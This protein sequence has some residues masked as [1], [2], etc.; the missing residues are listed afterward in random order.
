MIVHVIGVV[1]LLCILMIVSLSV[2]AAVF[3]VSLGMS[4]RL[5]LVLLQSAFCRY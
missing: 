5:L 4:T 3:I 1:V 2:R